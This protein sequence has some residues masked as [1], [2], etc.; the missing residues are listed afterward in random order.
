MNGHPPKPPLFPPPPLSQSSHNRSRRDAGRGHAA[1][2]TTCRHPARSATV[3]LDAQ[4][5]R[6]S[7]RF[8]FAVERPIRR[9][10]SGLRSEEHT[11]ELQSHS[12]LVCRLL[13]EKKK[14]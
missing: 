10:Q 1:H 3:E 9:W 4:R 8:A 11:S 5:Q 7:G 6:R 2:H 12:D 14:K 13:L